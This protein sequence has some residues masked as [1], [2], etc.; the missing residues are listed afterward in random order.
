MLRV[1]VPPTG[2]EVLGVNTRTGKTVEPAT[3]DPTV[4]EVNAMPPIWPPR[5]PD[6]T[7]TLAASLLVDTLIPVVL[8]TVAGP[9]VMPKR[10]IL[11]MP[12]GTATEVVKTTEDA[13]VRLSFG[14]PLMEDARDA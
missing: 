13:P 9:N 4:S 12:A 3:L 1:I 14:K 2:T 5:A 10:V 6:A 11:Y 8:P 7:P